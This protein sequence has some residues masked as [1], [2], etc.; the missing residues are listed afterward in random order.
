MSLN[1]AESDFVYFNGTTYLT[2]FDFNLETSQ[3][4]SFYVLQNVG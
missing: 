4:W 3:P 1:M 2:N